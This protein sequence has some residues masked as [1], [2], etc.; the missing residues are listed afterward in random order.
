MV[1]LSKVSMHGGGAVMLCSGTACPNSWEVSFG[2]S[3]SGAAGND[4][5]DKWD[6]ELEPHEISA[7]TL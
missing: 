2:A 7:Y 1:F 3:E 6:D 4:P 5:F